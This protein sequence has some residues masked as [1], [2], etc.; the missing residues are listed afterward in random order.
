MNL[1]PNIAINKLLEVSSHA[2]DRW[3]ER[4]S[5]EKQIMYDAIKESVPYGA[6]KGD[7]VCLLSTKHNAAFLVDTKSKLI[8]TVLHKDQ[9]IVNM[10]QL[11]LCKE[12]TETKEEDIKKNR[13]YKADTLLEE[14]FKLNPE[15]IDEQF[16]LTMM[17]VNSSLKDLSNIK[18]YKPCKTLLTY[19]DYMN[20]MI[21]N[22]KSRD[23]I[24]AKIKNIKEHLE[25]IKNAYN[26]VDNIVPSNG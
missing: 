19:A 11:G 7:S 10:Q 12:Y 8:V 21:A 17:V 23:K 4:F 3:R 18:D 24:N 20:K 26:N 15:I 22:C 5:K 25:D 16:Q 6:Q 2:Q 14:I 1:V 13:Q 9:A